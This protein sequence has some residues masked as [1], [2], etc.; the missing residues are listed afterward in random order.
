MSAYLDVQEVYLHFFLFTGTK[1]RPTE[2]LFG[3]P[4]HPRV[5]CVSQN[6]NKDLGA[7]QNGLN[8][9]L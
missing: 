8:R 7:V 3:L 6:C 4:N 2:V 5:S 1:K 9:E